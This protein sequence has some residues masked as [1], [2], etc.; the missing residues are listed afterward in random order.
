MKMTVSEPGK[1]PEVYPGATQSK[2]EKIMSQLYDKDME[3]GQLNVEV[4]KKVLWLCD[5]PPPV[6]RRQM[7]VF[8]SSNEW[9]HVARNDRQTYYLPPWTLEELQLA[10]SVLE[11]P[12]SDDEIENRFWN[13]GGVARNFFKLDPV[14]IKIAIHEL[15][16]SIEAI[17]E[18]GKLE[19]LLLGKRTSDTYGDFLL[20]NP[21]GDGRLYDTAI[22]SDMVREKLSERLFSITRS[23]LD[24]VYALLKGIPPAASLRG[25]IFENYA[26]SK[27]QEAK[28]FSA[29]SLVQSDRKEV[30]KM[31][32][33]D[34][35]DVFQRNAIAPALLNN[36]PYHKHQQ[37]N[38]ESIDGFFFP[39]LPVGEAPTMDEKNKRI[40]L[41]QMTVSKDN[42]VRASGIIYLLE[43]LGLLDLVKANPKRA[44]LVFVRPTDGSKDFQQQKILSG[45]TPPKDIRDLKGIGQ[46]TVNTLAKHF[47]VTSIA[48]LEAKVD[49]FEVGRCVAPTDKKHEA[50][51]ARAVEI[52]KKEVQYLKDQSSITMVDEIPQ[53]VYPL[54]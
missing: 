21:K 15:T 50:A 4:E 13:F 28:R 47:N 27:L 49:D 10:A 34:E 42:P 9:L 1:Q 18:S 26:H 53:Y 32:P 54:T 20:Y 19:N 2:L 44:A 35:I 33:S 52:W 25:W 46:G 36:G 24:K 23:K 17:T 8:T 6:K 7:V 3:A 39:K 40:L 29:R 48:D 51:W 43:K 41:F 14:N 5:G 30:F 45:G 11:Y 22:V 12:F 38:F 31:Q 37:K 16:E